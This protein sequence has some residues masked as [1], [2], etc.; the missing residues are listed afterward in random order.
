M[1]HEAMKA[2]AVLARQ[3]IEAEVIDCY[4]IKTIPVMLIQ[5]SLRRTGCC[6]VAESTTLLEV[7]AVP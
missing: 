4:S 5:S 6:V 2:A 1:V 7:S 3:G